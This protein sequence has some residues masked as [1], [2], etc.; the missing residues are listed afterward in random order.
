MPPLNYKGESGKLLLIKLLLPLI[1][2]SIFYPF[3]KSFIIFFA[4]LKSSSTEKIRKLGKGKG[5][6][7]V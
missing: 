5:S 6:P 1:I 3:E 7:G 4:F 2:C